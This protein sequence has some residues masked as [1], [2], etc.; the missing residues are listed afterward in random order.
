[1]WHEWGGFRRSGNGGIPFLISNRGYAI[2]LN[3]S[4]AS[5]FAVGRAQVAEPGPESSRNWSPPPWS[6]AASSGETH[7]DRLAI[8]L[9][10]GI[11][12]LW[13]VCRDSID[14]LLAGYADLTGHAPLPPKWALGFIQCKNRYRTQAELLSIAREYRRRQI[15]CDTLVIDWLWFK[16]FGTWNGLNRIGLTHKVC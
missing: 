9:D 2:L 8:L 7:P 16:E 13:I 4:W 12:D 10:Q 3:S 1:M 5:R 15:P 11:M 14:D 6:W